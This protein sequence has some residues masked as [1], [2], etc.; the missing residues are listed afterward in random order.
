MSSIPMHPH[1][2]EPAS[3]HGIGSVVRALVYPLSRIPASL[4]HLIASAGTGTEWLNP[5]IEARRAQLAR[6]KAIE[7]FAN[8][9]HFVRGL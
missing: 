9:P 4:R 5:A 3:G 8:D 6:Q 1:A 7:R 2:F